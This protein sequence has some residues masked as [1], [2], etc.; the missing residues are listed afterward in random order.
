M[1]NISRCG[2]SLSGAPKAF[3]I[4]GKGKANEDDM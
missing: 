3:K 2:V 1:Y 4:I